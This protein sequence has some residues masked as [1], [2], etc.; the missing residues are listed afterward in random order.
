MSDE[1]AP[2]KGGKKLLIAIII[3]ATVIVLAA[4]GVVA[5][6]LLGGGDDAA[7]EGPVA[8]AVVPL[9]DDMTL[10]LSDGRF[11]KLQL[12]LQLTE[13]A[14]EAEKDPAKFDGSKAQDAAVAVFAGYEYDELLAADKKEEARQKLAQLASERYDGQVMDVYYRQFVMQ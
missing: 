5:M 9:E 1:E 12:A 10:N 13:E 11:L 2:K 14:T 7:P 3:G 8:G 6:M 4:V